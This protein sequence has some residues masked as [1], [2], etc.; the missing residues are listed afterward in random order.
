[1]SG[2]F[3][4]FENATDWSGAV[5]V[6]RKMGEKKVALL[7]VLPTLIVLLGLAVYPTLYAL[8]I[9]LRV[10]LLYNPGASRFVGLDTY[11]G[12]FHDDFAVKSFWLTAVWTL[13][14]IAV[15]LPLGFA[16]ALLLD[17]QMR[18][19]GLLRTLLIVP[20]F[21]SPVAMGL[22]WRFMFEPVSGLINWVLRT[23]N[24]PGS[25]WLSSPQSALC[26]ILIAD[27]WQWTPF[28][29]LV[30]L[31]GMQSVSTEI[32]EAAH[33][34]GLRGTFYLRKILLPLIWPIVLVVLLIRLVDS[35]KV[36]DLFY[37]MTRGGPGS[38]T[39]VSGVYGFTLFQTGRLSD[40]A[41]LGVV[42]LL[43]IN[44]LVSLVLRVLYRQERRAISQ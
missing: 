44:V 2:L 19:S 20:V 4:K 31:A 42:L 26:A 9:S 28:V 5:R 18:V 17:R 1:M 21:I 6:G 16:L 32:V 37:L 14:V 7:L 35:I 33:L 38:S 27:T 10:Y 24:L 15:Q 41:A 30:L 39:L 12:L 34:D 22:T 29:A 23:S 43:A 25:L 40:V 8:W 36:F 13:L 11:W 3:A